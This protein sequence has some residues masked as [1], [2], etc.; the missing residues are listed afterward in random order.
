MCPV[1]NDLLNKLVH[2]GTCLAGGVD[3][4]FM[5]VTLGIHTVQRE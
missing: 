5:C 2:L 4:R 1:W 3:Y